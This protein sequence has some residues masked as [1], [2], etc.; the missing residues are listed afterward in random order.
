MNFKKDFPVIVLS[1]LGENHRLS[2]DSESFLN[3]L[4][5]EFIKIIVNLCND[6]LN[7]IDYEKQIIK[8][9][10][11]KR[12][13]T[14]EIETSIQLLFPKEIVDY[15]I[16]SYKNVVYYKSKIFFSESV[17]ENIIQK[18]ILNNVKITKNSIK[19]LAFLTETLV[20]DILSS[21]G[22][23]VNDTTITKKGLS[24]VFK[25]NKEL[26][27]ILKVLKVSI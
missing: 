10:I 21:F 14:R 18:Y 3:L 17:T 12:F 13:T 20:Y 4:C 8:K 2:K 22:D 27:E 1:I 11:K 26:K 24:K 9:S 5:F 15:F 19:F 25:E 23:I 7:P 6:L 16:K